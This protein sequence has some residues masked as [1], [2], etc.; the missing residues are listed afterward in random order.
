MGDG[1]GAGGKLGAEVDRCPGAQNRDI[2]VAQKLLLSRVHVDRDTVVMEDFNLVGAELSGGRGVEEAG[3]RVAELAHRKAI[4]LA[5]VEAQLLDTTGDALLDEVAE[6][7][8]TTGDGTCLF[9]EV[10][11]LDDIAA[12]IQDDSRAFPITRPV[13][14]AI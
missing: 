7:A 11:E 6:E 14:A 9:E 3:V 13:R 10:E 12:G 8:L 4:A 1:G 2:V 5:P